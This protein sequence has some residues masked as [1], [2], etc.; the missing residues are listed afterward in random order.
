MGQEAETEQRRAAFAA[1]QVNEALC[2]IAGPAARVM[3]CLP[4]HRGEEITSDVMDGPRSLVF[5]QSENRLHVQ[6]G[7]LVELLGDAR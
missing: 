7:L 1:F 4:A 5:E 3:H 2:S 6:K